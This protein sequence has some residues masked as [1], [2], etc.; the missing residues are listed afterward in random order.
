MEN[1]MYQFEA[2]K[3]LFLAHLERHRYSSET[4][5]GYDKDLECFRRYIVSGGGK[6]DFSL[7][8]IGKNHLLG[9]MDDGR[10]R[11]N[12]ASTI[13]RRLSTLK[14]FYKFLVYELDYPVDVAARIR[15]PKVYIPLKNI[16]T[17]EE[18][19]RLLSSA[20]QISP[21]YHLLFSVIYYTGSRLTPV[22]T[23]ERSH[24]R[25]EES[26]IYFPKVK[27]G[28][29]L[30]LPINDHL[31]G[32]FEHYFAEQSLEDSVYIFQSPRCPNQPLSPS[33]I[34]NKLRLA[35]KYAAVNQSITP[36][37]LRHCTATHLTIRNVPQQK[38][39]SILGHSDL[40]STMRYQHLSVEHLRDSLN[41]L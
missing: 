32:V 23:L 2:C 15:I 39:A 21:C 9:F 3:Q 19:E 28:K 41:M 37:T 12:K 26:V 27:G 14:S 8:E 5:N 40:R 16:L 35:A 18:V 22:R 30:Y 38:I 17:E 11:G 36:H 20:L 7:E 29:D 6:H 24:V 25:L 1:Q 10:E 31:K 34:R 4:S 13:G 33:D